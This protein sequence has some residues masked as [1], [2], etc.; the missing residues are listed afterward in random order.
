MRSDRPPGTFGAGESVSFGDTTPTA[1][2]TDHGIVDD[3]PP[4]NNTKNEKNYTTNT[5]QD[6]IDD[7]VD[8][9]DD[10]TATTAAS[11]APSTFDIADPVLVTEVNMDDTVVDS[12]FN[13]YFCASG[14]VDVAQLQAEQE[15]IDHHEPLQIFPYDTSDLAADMKRGVR[16]SQR[17]SRPWRRRT[18]VRKRRRRR[19]RRNSAP[20]SPTDNLD[21]ISALQDEH[22]LIALPDEASTLRALHVGESTAPDHILKLAAA[23]AVAPDLH[24]LNDDAPV[25]DVDGYLDSV[26][27]STPEVIRALHNFRSKIVNEGWS[28][29]AYYEHLHATDPDSLAR[30]CAHLDAGA[31][32]STTNQLGILS[33][34]VAIPNCT[35]MFRVADG[36]IHR[37][38]GYGYAKL[39]AKSNQVLRH[40]VWYTP[41]LP[42]TIFSPTA[43]G[44]EYGCAGYA[45]VGFFG[46]GT[47]STLR[48][49]HCRT[50]TQN[51][52][53]ECTL[54]DGLLFPCR[55]FFPIPRMTLRP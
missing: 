48:L 49:L 37:P 52:D 10:A 31:Q 6:G 35:K 24:C 1:D 18:S 3:L 38:L 19:Y 45:T 33:D 46:S 8:I 43:L 11:S 54:R 25:E 34:Y 4:T 44:R 50:K 53:L 36:T 14:D 17:P 12:S 47:S 27:Q 42:A 7:I 39:R 40:R 9:A 23:C 32:G 55:L 51:I 21:M 30:L 5:K 41:S 28:V 26:V 29:Q 16:V 22:R 2:S 20:S 13:D 15:L